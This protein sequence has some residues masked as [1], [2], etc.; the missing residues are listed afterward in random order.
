MHIARAGGALDFE[1]VAQVVVE[2]LQRLDQQIIHRKP[3]RPAPVRIAAEQARAD[4]AG[5]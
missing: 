5:S 4:S 3:D 1:I 2:L